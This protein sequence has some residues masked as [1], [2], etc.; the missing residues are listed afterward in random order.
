MSETNERCLKCNGKGTIPEFA[1]VNDGKCVMCKGTGRLNVAA[2]AAE[3]ARMLPLRVAALA[4]Y[5]VDRSACCSACQKRVEPRFVEAHEWRAFGHRPSIV[6]L[7]IPC[8][9]KQGF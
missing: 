5:E 4:A 2:V 6:V 9:I 1:H 8:A 7:C 3:R